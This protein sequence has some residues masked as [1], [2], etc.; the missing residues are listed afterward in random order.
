MSKIQLTSKFSF[1]ANTIPS[2]AWALIEIIKD[3][4]L[5][6]A[7]RAE[8]SNAFDLD[9][10][11]QKKRLNIKQLVELPLLQSIYTECL[12]MHVSINFTRGITDNYTL[13][14]YALKKGSLIQAPTM[15]AHF[16][17]TIWD[18]PE[19]PASEFWAGRHLK[20]IEEVDKSGVKRTV[21]K[22]SI[23]GRSGGFFPFG[24]M[25]ENPQV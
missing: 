19:H 15:V 20:D 9:P 18:E 7:V 11:S 6:N 24:R 21:T 8:A 12:R 22:F 10:M 3:K 13:G 16:D 2:A 4:D 1:N 25:L 14:G 23:T 17:P 5:F